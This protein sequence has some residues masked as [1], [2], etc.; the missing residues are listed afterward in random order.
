MHPALS[1]PSATPLRSG[2]KRV[3]PFCICFYCICRRARVGLRR[4]LYPF[5]RVTAHASR[6]SAHDSEGEG[7]RGGGAAYRRAPPPSACTQRGGNGERRYVAYA[8]G[9]ARSHC[10]VLYHIRRDEITVRVLCQSERNFKFC[11]G[12][13]RQMLDSRLVEVAIP[14]VPYP[15]RGGTCVYFVKAS[16]GGRPA[17][18]SASTPRAGP[19]GRLRRRFATCP[20]K[21]SF[22]G[23]SRALA[24]RDSRH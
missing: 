22:F 6:N 21:Q 17:S 20:P 3:R 24:A 9:I 5:R 10:R 23:A 12:C 11:L 15:P 18:S 14:P 7:K 16:S 8:H 1:S 19:C 2:D 4:I 13:Q